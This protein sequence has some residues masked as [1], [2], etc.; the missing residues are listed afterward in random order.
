MSVASDDQIMRELKTE[1]QKWIIRTFPSR[2]GNGIDEVE[3]RIKMKEEADA[4]IEYNFKERSQGKEGTPSP[5]V[6]A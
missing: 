2:L 1:A 6:K 5:D 3:V 4:W